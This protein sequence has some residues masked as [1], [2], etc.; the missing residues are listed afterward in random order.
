MTFTGLKTSQ[1]DKPDLWKATSSL[2]LSR[3][4]IKDGLVDWDCPEAIN[5]SDMKKA[6]SHIRSEGTFPVSGST[7]QPSMHRSS[8]GLLQKN[9][10][11]P[12]GD[13]RERRHAYQPVTLQ[14][15][16]D[17]KEDQNSVGQ[18]PISDTKIAAVKAK[19]DAWLQPGS[20]GYGILKEGKLRMCLLDGF[21]LFCPQMVSVMEVI[22]IKLFLLVS[23]AKATQRREARD[24][25]VTLEGFW[26]DPPGYVDKIVWPNYAAAH[27]WLFEGGN[28]EGKLM[29]DVLRENGIQAQVDKGLDVDF[30]VTLDWAVDSIMRSLESHQ[31]GNYDLR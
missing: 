18:C 30:E 17:S 5:I 26:K 29:T 28:V 27:E 25:Y 13:A 4:P 22:D 23:R 31:A 21:L 8:H 1:S 3:L 9:P 19:V 6:L 15:D 11:P 14:P 24:G 2:S 7:D 16:V 20:P 10:E 12:I